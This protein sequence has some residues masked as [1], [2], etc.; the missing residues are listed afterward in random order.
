MIMANSIKQIVIEIDIEKQDLY[1]V[2]WNLNDWV[3]SKYIRSYRT[4]DE[5]E[6]I[7]VWPDEELKEI[8]LSEK[9]F[10]KIKNIINK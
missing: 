8:V 1:S 5:D 4:L 6:K 2:Y 3:S 9:D 10:Q 7:Q